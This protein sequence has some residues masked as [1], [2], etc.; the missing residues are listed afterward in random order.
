MQQTY[1]NGQSPTIVSNISPRLLSWAKFANQLNSQAS[2][3]S[4]HLRPV[5]PSG[6][7]RRHHIPSPLHIH[8][9]PILPLSIMVLVG[10][11]HWHWHGD[12]RLHMPPRLCDRRTEW[13][14]LLDRLLHDPP[15]A[16]VP[17]RRL[18]YRF[19][20]CCLVLVPDPCLD[21][22]AIVVLPPMDHSDLCNIRSVF[23]RRP[24]DWCWN[25]LPHLRSWRLLGPEYGKGWDE[26]SSRA[27]YTSPWP[28]TSN[29]LF[30]LLRRNCRPILL[31][32]SAMARRGPGRLED[33]AQAI[34]DDQRCCRSDNAASHIPNHGDSSW[35][36]IRPPISTEPRVVF[37]DFRR[38]ANSPDIDCLCRVASRSIPPTELHRLETQQENCHPREGGDSPTQYF[39]AGR[40][41]TGIS[42]RA[43]WWR[44]GNES[45]IHLS[46]SDALRR[47]MIP[48]HFTAF[49]ASILSGLNFSYMIWEP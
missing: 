44:C 20:S 13:P 48:L 33:V 24:I 42:S 46:Q 25:D 12:D 1:L 26:D 27:C 35:Q 34:L 32:Q 3:K 45:V 49:W 18:L 6:S 8:P 41:I 19:Q 38:A 16:L 15:R 17:R 22:Q 2:Y 31:H 30:R 5:D 23:F 21:L 29:V 14:T 11:R 37:L 9:I 47:I 36:R 10:C 39:Y 43:F 4:L 7:R 28:N 40:G